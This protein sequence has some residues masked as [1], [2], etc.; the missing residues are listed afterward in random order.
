MPWLSKI[1]GAQYLGKRNIKALC[2]NVTFHEQQECGYG[3]P[4]LPL[5]TRP[6]ADMSEWFLSLSGKALAEA[7][8]ARGSD[9]KLNPHS[10]CLII[11]CDGFQK[12]NISLLS[13]AQ[14]RMK[15]NWRGPFSKFLFH[16]E[17]E[18]FPLSQLFGVVCDTLCSP[19]KCC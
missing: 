14:K 16:T 6:S 3:F 4:S 8:V 1:D 19:I 7:H 17:L 11:N 5:A 2:R 10:C 18:V 15:V 13:Y 12:I 9:G